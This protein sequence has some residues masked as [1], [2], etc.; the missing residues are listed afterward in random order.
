MTRTGSVFNTSP[1]VADPAAGDLDG[2]DFLRIGIDPEAN[3]RLSRAFD[4][5]CFLASHGISGSNQIDTDP[6]LAHAALSSCQFVVRQVG[7]F[8]LLIPP[9]KQT[10]FA[11]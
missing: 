3:R 5:P 1:R 11:G 2:P 10:G 4:G 6:R 7:S 8:G 9:G